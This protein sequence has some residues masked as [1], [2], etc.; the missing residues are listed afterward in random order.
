MLLHLWFCIV[1][2]NKTCMFPMSWNR[3]YGQENLDIKLL[4]VLSYLLLRWLLEL[5][6]V[7]I[8]VSTEADSCSHLN[9]NF[10]TKTRQDYGYILVLFDL[11]T[12]SPASVSAF[13]AFTYSIIRQGTSCPTAL[14]KTEMLIPVRKQNNFCCVWQYRSCVLLFNIQ[15]IPAPLLLRILVSLLFHVECFRI[16]ATFTT[17]QHYSDYSN[18]SQ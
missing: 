17:I 4:P 2:C 15:L 13:H 9:A 5:L 14:P 3:C 18:L 11:S 1:L 10:S 12:Q 6:L 16:A 7:T 8:T